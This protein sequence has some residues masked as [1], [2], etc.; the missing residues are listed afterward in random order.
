MTPYDGNRAVDDKQ[1]KFGKGV[2]MKASSRR[3]SPPTARRA[4]RLHRPQY[5]EALTLVERLHRRLLDVIKDELIAAAAPTSPRCGAAALQYRRQ[6][7]HRRRIGIPA[8]TISAPTS[9]TISRSWSR[10]ASSTTSAR[11]STGA[12]CASSSPTRAG[13]KS[14]TPSTRLYRKHV[15]TVEQVGGINADEFFSA[16]QQGAAPARALLDRPDS[17]YRL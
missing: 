13:S 3:S 15:R 10:W 9:P 5:L 2:N 11:A 7:A 6:G 8:A 12:R 4:L 16:Q 1:N 14:A 17:F